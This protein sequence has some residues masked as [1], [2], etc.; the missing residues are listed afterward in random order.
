[1]VETFHK[2]LVVFH[3]FFA[4][5]SQ[6]SDNMW[7]LSWEAIGVA[8]PRFRGLF[9]P[10]ISSSYKVHLVSLNP[11]AVVKGK[12]EEGKNRG[13]IWIQ[14]QRWMGWHGYVYAGV[15]VKS[16]E[17]RQKWDWEHIFGDTE[18]SI[19]RSFVQIWARTKVAKWKIQVNNFLGLIIMFSFYYFITPKIVLS[20]LKVITRVLSMNSLLTCT[21]LLLL[22]KGDPLTWLLWPTVYLEC[23]LLF[24][25]AVLS[26]LCLGS[27]FWFLSLLWYNL[28]DTGSCCLGTLSVIL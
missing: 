27:I 26:F 23:F 3:C 11:T 18:C 1:M 20:Y 22:P 9:H 8:V 25:T 5:E 15:E 28:W 16:G 4:F 10:E 17:R 12:R 13:D 19:R 7:A 21:F 14:S 6:G 24:H 2:C